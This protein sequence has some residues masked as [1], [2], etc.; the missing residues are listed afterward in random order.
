[1]YLT[2][3]TTGRA[4]SLAQA[5]YHVALL[6]SGGVVF[7]GVALLISS[8]VE[9]EYTAPVASFCVVMCLTVVLGDGPLRTLSP[10]AFINGIQFYDRHTGLL[11]GAIPWVQGSVNLAVAAALVGCSV[12]LMQ[13]R[14]F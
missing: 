11:T 3:R 6:V 5:C 13:R 9:G 2:A 8:L 14:E 1:M 10:F 12:A 4:N 7:F